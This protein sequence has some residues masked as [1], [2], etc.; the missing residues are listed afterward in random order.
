M[1]K[2]SYLTITI[3]S[4][5][6]SQANADD[7]Q[8][9][10]TAS[11]QSQYAAS[12][13]NVAQYSVSANKLEDANVTNTKELDKVLPGVNITNADS[14]L[15]STSS[16]RGIS[17]A[18][19]Y[20]N[21]AITL[22]IDG[23]PQPSISFNRPLGDVQQVE[24][25]KGPQGTLYG[26]SAQ[27]GIINIV[28]QQPGKDYRG[29]ISGGYGLRNSYRGK[30]SLS[31]PLAEGLLYAGITGL[32]E[33]EKGRLTNPATG[34]KNLGGQKDDL[35]Q[36]QLRLAP[37]NQPWEVNVN[38]VSECLNTSQGLA[39]TPDNPGYTL[40]QISGN[41]PDP[42]I[43]RCL[44]S[45]S[46][47]GK[48]S[49]DNWLF[50]AISSWEQI[51]I[52]RYFGVPLRPMI[53]SQN[54]RWL[55]DIQEVRAS[56]HGAGKTVD[57]VAGLY[58]QNIRQNKLIRAFNNDWQQSPG[59]TDGHIRVQSLAAYTDLSWH[60]NPQWDLGAG[61][62]VSHDSANALITT[63]TDTIQRH[64]TVNKNN[65][66]GQL[67]AGYQLTTQNRIYARIAQ[68][69]KPTGF[70][71]HPNAKV[72]QPEPYQPETSL[73][74]EIGHNYTGH[75]LLLQSALFYTSTN[76]VQMYK[77]RTDN[78]GLFELKNFGDT[79][80]YGAELTATYYFMPGWEIGG[81][82]NLIHAKFT[83]SLKNGNFANKRSP[84]VPDYSGNIHISGTLNTPVGIL[85]PWLGFNVSGSYTFDEAEFLQ[86]GWTTTD[87][88][89]GWQATDRITLSAYVNNVFD[90][91][92]FTY[93]NP[94]YG[95]SNTGRTAGLNVKVDLF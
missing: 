15:F 16:I 86:T 67:S 20:Y 25:L 26:K 39:V 90:K 91:R 88:R 49:T 8:I 50:T 34:H 78:S 46:L 21:T 18:N 83:G 32:R 13:Q 23:I 10:V 38:Y 93:A 75:D 56:T 40:G 43:R 76:N 84:F 89:L 68:G 74:Y 5:L 2:L 72:L 17:S 33:E 62:R 82:I 52:T 79:Q 28:T 47:N 69:Y 42:Y 92:Y 63:D 29:Y 41:A 4:A 7:Q 51:K 48:Y 44:Q 60:I 73:S 31:G 95:Y 57:V 45:Q 22:Y 66:L 9:V 54:E 55:Q 27:G 3:V 24:L 53:S 77:E 80:V 87:L 30:F 35:G 19:D 12:S 65:I 36:L 70:D 1:K 81:N 59:S 58:R 14:V 71:F 6:I 94:Y 11:K 85:N 64:G 37:D 61:I